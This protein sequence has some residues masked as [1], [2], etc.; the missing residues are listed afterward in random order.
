MALSRNTLL[1][2]R[3]C[4]DG[5]IFCEITLNWSPGRLQVEMSERY[6]VWC[7]FV[8]TNI[9]RQRYGEIQSNFHVEVS[10]RVLTVRELDYGTLLSLFEVELVKAFCYLHKRPS[11]DHDAFLETILSLQGLPTQAFNPDRESPRSHT[12]DKMLGFGH[13]QRFQS[14]CDNCNDHVTCMRVDARA[15]AQLFQVKRCPEC[16]NHLRFLDEIPGQ[17]IPIQINTYKQPTHRYAIS[18]LEMI[19]SIL[20][21]KRVSPDKFIP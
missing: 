19:D 3:L 9:K 11:I 2:K 20:K 13:K 1:L 21:K 7:A 14:V 8:P 4:E 18:S 15:A 5:D 12:E 10:K 16:G 6:D 17:L